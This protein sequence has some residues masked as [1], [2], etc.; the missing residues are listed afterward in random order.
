MSLRL[1]NIRIYTL[2]K[3]GFV[4]TVNQFIEFKTFM[5][6]SDTIDGCFSSVKIHGVF[7]SLKEY[8]FLLW[9]SIVD[10]HGERTFFYKYFKWLIKR[11]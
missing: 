7:I 10:G 8:F 1:Y 5:L 3:K 4:C 11:I 9:G 2:K 6:K